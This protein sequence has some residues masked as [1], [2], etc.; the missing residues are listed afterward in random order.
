MAQKASG[1]EALLL[2][3]KRCTEGYPGVSVT[4]FSESWADGLA[5]AAIVAHHRPDALDF[6]KAAD[7]ARTAGPRAVHELAFRVAESLGVPALLDA[8]GACFFK[9]LLL[10]F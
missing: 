2:W 8:E 4:N 3:C 9:N 6:A 10:F 1:K 5:F 7:L